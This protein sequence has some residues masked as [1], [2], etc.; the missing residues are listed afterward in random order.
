[1]D[2]TDFTSA[3]LSGASFAHA[4]L[5]HVRFDGAKVDDLECFNTAFVDTDLQV[6]CQAHVRHGAQSMVDYHSVVRSVSASNLRDFLSGA[7][8]PLLFADYII[9]CARGLRSQERSSL[10]RSVF[11]SYGEPDVSFASKL[12][13]ALSGEGVSTYLFRENATPGQR[14]YRL[15]HVAANEYDRIILVCSRDSLT[16][17]G[18]MNEL[19]EV[20]QREAREGGEDRLIPV[21]LDSYVFEQWEPT[22]PGLKRA[23]CDRVVADFTQWRV[24]AKF[25][26][27][28][29]RLLE[30][31]RQPTRPQGYSPNPLRPT[32]E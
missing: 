18:V 11:I 5:R 28:V 8:M 31:L 10:L 23:V 13:A 12:R 19:R 6:L 4:R 2:H 22:E 26:E 24:D 14:L 20:L 29:R 15:M 21:R 17:A 16:R 1:L 27:G 25:R 3:D 7:G 32:L 9:D 30:A